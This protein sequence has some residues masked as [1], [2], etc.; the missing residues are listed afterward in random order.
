MLKMALWYDA[1]YV[2]PTAINDENFTHANL[3]A[4][5]E[6]SELESAWPALMLVKNGAN[7]SVKCCVD[8]RIF[9]TNLE[10]APSASPNVVTTI[11]RFHK[12]GSITVLENALYSLLAQ[13]DCDV[14]P[15][16][17]VQDLT[18]E[19]LTELSTMLS[20][21]PFKAECTVKIKEYYSD[22]SCP[23]LR[24]L[25]LN[26]ELRLA[27][28]RYVAFLDYDDILFPHAYHWLLGRLKKTG[29]NASFGLIY[30]T[31]SNLS[32]QKIKQRTVVYDYG[33]SFSDF[34]YGNHTPIH[35]FMLDISKIRVQEIEFFKCMKYN[36]DYYLTLQVFTEKDTDWESLHHRQFIGDYYH[37]E[38]NTQT[39]ANL[40]HERNQLIKSGE[41]IDSELK[42]DLLKNKIAAKKKN[43]A[44]T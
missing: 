33:K 16:I 41:Y 1:G 26:Q 13:V 38:D 39:L 14:Q 2:I 23:D 27:N 4:R 34:F 31:I 40:S 44:A 22:D 7:R 17:A 20:T 10:P 42:I 11:I 19:M 29:K 36:E 28:T 24:S 6:V 3:L 9:I 12:S 5:W 25:M 32:E 15:I 18:A 30:T 21:I 35:G 43:S 37:Y 8:A